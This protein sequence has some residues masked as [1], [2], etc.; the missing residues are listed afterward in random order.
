MNVITAR[1]NKIAERFNNGTLVAEVGTVL[2]LEEA[3]VAQEMLE[4][5]PHKRG[6]I[7]LS[8]IVA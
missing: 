5:T 4:C 1:L 8:M 2:S 3:R 6:K 7:V